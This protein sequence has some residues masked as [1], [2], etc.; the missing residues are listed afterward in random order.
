MRVLL[1]GRDIGLLDERLAR[2]LSGRPSEKVV[3]GVA[4]SAE[5]A[6]EARA[7]ELRLL[8]G[9]AAVFVMLTLA[10][11]FTIVVPRAPRALGLMGLIVAI[12]VVVTGGLL[13][14]LD[15]LMLG[16]HRKRVEARGT[17][18]LPPGT[19]VRL[20]A[21]LLRSG[22]D[23]WLWPTIKVEELGVRER[24][25]EHQRLTYVEQLTLSDGRRTIRLDALFM[26]NGQAVLEQAWRRIQAARPAL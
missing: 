15:A 22:G 6:I 8:F 11:V 5:A 2:R 3:E 7:R 26:T 4:I 9:G 19:E 24:Q 14:V 21:T 20:D 17:P 12:V 10:V 13:F 18:G 25:G 16:D 23:A 1:N